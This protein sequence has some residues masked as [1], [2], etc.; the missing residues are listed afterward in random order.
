MISNQPYL[1][2]Y[3]SPF[4]EAI[5]KGIQPDLSKLDQAGLKQPHSLNA[6]GL[7]MGTTIQYW[8]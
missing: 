1:T 6:F 4:N 8:L 5:S 3:L 7:K 2:F